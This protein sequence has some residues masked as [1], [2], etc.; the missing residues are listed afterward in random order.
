ALVTG[1][2]ASTSGRG[3]AFGTTPASGEATG[4]AVCTAAGLAMAGASTGNGASGALALR[5]VELVLRKKRPPKMASANTATAPTHKRGERRAR[6]V[7]VGSGVT[8]SAAGNDGTETVGAV[9]SDAAA[10]GPDASVDKRPDGSARSG[11]SDSIETMAR[12]RPDT[13]AGA[14]ASAS[15]AS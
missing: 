6:G 5:A 15:S 13:V 14:S 3:S 1:G 7:R 9:C 2:T 11:R 4:R 12:R 8:S 10:P